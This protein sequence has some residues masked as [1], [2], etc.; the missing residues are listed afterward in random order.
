M[1]QN[2]FGTAGLGRAILRL[3]R[4]WF[5]IRFHLWTRIC[6]VTDLACVGENLWERTCGFLGVF[7]IS[8]VE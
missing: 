7:L 1:T 2:V 6:Y 3:F 4:A 5:H 8:S